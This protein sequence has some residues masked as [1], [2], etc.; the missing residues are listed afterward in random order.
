MIEFSD[1]RCN[2]CGRTPDQISE[3]ILAGQDEDMTPEEFVRQEEGTFNPD[4][5]HFWCTSCYIQADMPLGV[6]R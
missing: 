2:G 6:G 3:Y 5:G 4:N 1:I